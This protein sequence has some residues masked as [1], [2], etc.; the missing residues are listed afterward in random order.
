MRRTTHWSHH[1]RRGTNDSLPVF[2]GLLGGPFSDVVNN[3]ISVCCKLKRSQLVR[4]ASCEDWRRI[5]KLSSSGRRLHALPRYLFSR[6]HHDQR[7]GSDCGADTLYY[8]PPRSVQGSVLVL[9]A[10]LYRWMYDGHITGC[11]KHNSRLV[12]KSKLAKIGGTSML[13]LQVTWARCHEAWGVLGPTC[14][15]EECRAVRPTNVR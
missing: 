13:N 4:C 10:E 2:P 8:R 15:S 11:N 1:T 7:N 3:L 5:H 6:L 9:E 14:I 12:F